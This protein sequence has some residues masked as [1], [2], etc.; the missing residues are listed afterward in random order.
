MYTTILQALDQ[1]YL[2]KKSRDFKGQ[3]EIADLIIEEWIP[4]ILADRK[5]VGA[6]HYTEE[7]TLG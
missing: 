4:E 7:D 5:P 2:A 6:T 3:L 1:Y